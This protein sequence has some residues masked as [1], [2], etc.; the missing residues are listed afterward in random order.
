MQN[1]SPQLSL[2]TKPSTLSSDSAQD[3]S[4]LEGDCNQLIKAAV[5]A[6]KLNRKFIGFEK[7][8]NYYQISQQRLSEYGILFARGRKTTSAL[9]P[10]NGKQKEGS[11]ARGL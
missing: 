11:V 7:D 1:L 8:R 6:K 9:V 2:L 5:A 10:L 3:I 4:I